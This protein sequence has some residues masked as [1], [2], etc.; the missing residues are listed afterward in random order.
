VRAI[1]PL[2]AA[3]ALLS[4]C[5]PSRV[6]V[7]VALP[8]GAV[9][10]PAS[11]E[12]VVRDGERCGAVDAP[13]GEERIRRTWTEGADAPAIG[14]VSSDRYTVSVTVRDATCA[15][16]GYGCVAVDGGPDEV[17]I[18][19]EPASGDGCP[20]GERCAA[21][22]CEPGTPDDAGAMDA[23]PGEDGGAREDAGPGDAGP[24]D[25]GP[26]CVDDVDCGPQG[27]GR[28][29]GGACERC[30]PTRL[31]A[32]NFH[33]PGGIGR[34]LAVEGVTAAGLSETSLAV[35]YSE[36]RG[37]PVVVVKAIELRRYELL[38]TEAEEPGF[39]AVGGLTVDTPLHCASVGTG[40]DV[41]LGCIAQVDGGPIDIVAGRLF[42][43][44]FSERFETMGDFPAGPT[45]A[46]RAPAGG[47]ARIGW[48]GAYD[49]PV[50]A[51]LSSLTLAAAATPVRTAPAIGN[52]DVVAISGSDG[53][54]AVVSDAARL[55]FWRSDVG[56]APTV[57]DRTLGG[58]DASLTLESD[59]GYL[60]AYGNEAQVWLRRLAC[61]DSCGFTPGDPPDA[62]L[63]AEGPVTRVV[64]EAIDGGGAVVSYVVNNELRARIVG[65]DLAPAGPAWLLSSEVPER[66]ILALDGDVWEHDGTVNAVFGSISQSGVADPDRGVVFGLRFDRACEP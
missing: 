52:T 3:V 47:E 36:L 54:W 40:D 27:I 12:L 9:S 42:A 58:S 13:V 33:P 22:V 7:V 38:S 44:G 25:A 48:R 30:E 18:V 16:I 5:D 56:F 50:G 57:V 41:T 63:E 23:G 20:M 61:D 43:G 8:A 29:I 53:P 26:E 65:A 32:A 64:V 15:I 17:R 55:Y 49:G 6:D 31:A 19:V 62:A 1:P 4:A 60:L 21:G 11:Y 24:R 46:N 66:E 51:S 2:L 39:D 10:D 45:F 34:V 14:R 37:P 35:L 28:C 59:G